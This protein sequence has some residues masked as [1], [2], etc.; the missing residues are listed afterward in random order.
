MLCSIIKTILEAVRERFV[1]P[2]YHAYVR[3]DSGAEQRVVLPKCT[4]DAEFVADPFL[5]RHDGV[6]YLFFE[7]LYANRGNRGRAKG[8]IGCFRQVGDSWE[9]V[10][11]VL[12]SESHLSYPQVFSVDGRIYMIPES[13][14]ANEVALYE[15]TEFPVQWEKK[16]VLLNGKYV[17]S[18]IVRHNGMFYIMTTPEDALLPPEVWLSDCLHVNW[19]KHPQS[20]NMLSS[21]AFRRNGGA[22]RNDEGRLFRIA[23]D[24]DGGYGKLLY[25][26]PIAKLSP[27]LYEEGNPEKLADAISW[28]QNG[29][30]HT[31]NAIF[32]SYHKIEVVDRHFNTVKTPLDFLSSAIWFVLDGVAFVA[33]KLI[34]HR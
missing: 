20:G 23:Q 33:K 12:E 7:G 29:L 25:R 1:R 11:V 30:H 6:T 4:L 26:I 28:Q 31:Y 9:Y 32:Y 34:F 16:A 8:V 15:A 17:D 21:R 2:H 5:F 24:C 22:I 13:G 10:G 19:K 18:S 3:L 27:E 14:Q